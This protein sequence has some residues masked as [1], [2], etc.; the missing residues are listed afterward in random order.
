MEKLNRRPTYTEFRENA[1][2]GTKIFEKD[3]VHGLKQ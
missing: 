1:S 2:F 3:M